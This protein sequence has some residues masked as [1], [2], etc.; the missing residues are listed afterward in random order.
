MIRGIVFGCVYN[1]I[2][3][4]FNDHRPYALCAFAGEWVHILAYL[5][6]FKICFLDHIA[7]LDDL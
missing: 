2:P 6:R 7:P 5:V 4:G 3:R 1:E